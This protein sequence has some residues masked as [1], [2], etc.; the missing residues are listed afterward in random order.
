MSFWL[1][2]VGCHLS[3]AWW[4]VPCLHSGSEPAKPWATE[5]ERANPTT[6]PQGWPPSVFSW[7]SPGDVSQDLKEKLCFHSSDVPC[8]SHQ[9]AAGSSPSVLTFPSLF[10][11]SA[12]LLPESPMPTKWQ[13]CPAALRIPMLLWPPGLCL[14]EHKVLHPPTVSKAALFQLSADRVTGAQNKFEMASTTLF[15]QTSFLS[16]DYGL[17][18]CPSVF[19]N[20]PRYV[21]IPEW[22]P[23]VAQTL[24]HVIFLSSFL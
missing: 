18:F 9:N 16:D 5:A 8:V 21:W 2:Y 19:W 15:S 1:C 10:L 20:M 14:R 23:S 24:I 17:L 4:V 7:E 6:W 3:V 11:R 22:A 13:Y 12:R